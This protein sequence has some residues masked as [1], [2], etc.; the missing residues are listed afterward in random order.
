MV[1]IASLLARIQ[2]FFDVG[3]RQQKH[4]L[5]TVSFHLFRC[6]LFSRIFLIGR[7]RL[8]NLILYRF[9]FPSFG[10]ATILRR[11]NFLVRTFLGQVLF[12]STGPSEYLLR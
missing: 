3:A 12:R 1:A 6:E 10:H 5:A 7:L 2:I 9:A 4:F 11:W 8:L